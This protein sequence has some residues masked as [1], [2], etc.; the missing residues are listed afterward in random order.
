[1]SNKLL[2][3]CSKHIFQ[4]YGHASIKVIMDIVKIA[5]NS[6]INFSIDYNLENALISKL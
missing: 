1:M 2:K 6:G 4:R 3:Q 5:T